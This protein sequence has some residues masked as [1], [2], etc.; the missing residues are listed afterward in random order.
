MYLLIH[1][2]SLPFIFLQKIV[3]KWCVDDSPESSNMRYYVFITVE[4]FITP[5]SLYTFDE[6]G[7]IACGDAI[8]HNTSKYF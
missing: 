4:L 7:N 2:L 8:L 5:F 1:L 6:N 3:L